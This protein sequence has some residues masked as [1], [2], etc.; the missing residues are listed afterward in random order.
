M[1][2]QSTSSPIFLTLISLI[3]LGLAISLGL[4][5]CGG[6]GDGGGGGPSMMVMPTPDAAPKV[7]SRP[8]N[9]SL[10]T[11]GRTSTRDLSTYFEDDEA[12]TY[13][14]STGDTEV[15]TV[16][17]SGTE[18]TVTSVG[19]GSAT[20][21]ITATDPGG[22]TAS[23][24]FT[25]TVTEPSGA[26]SGPPDLVI[27]SI[28]MR[29]AGPSSRR[30]EE[31]D[32]R[33]QVLNQGTG[34]ADRYRIRYLQS[35]DDLVIEPTDS[36]AASSDNRIGLNP[37]EGDE[38]TSADFDTPGAGTYYYGAC[39]E[40]TEAD[41]DE[42]NTD[43]NCSNATQVIVRADGSVSITELGSGGSPPPPPSGD[44][45]GNTQATATSIAGSA[46]GRIDPAGDV[47]YFSFRVSSSGT[48][49]VATSGSTDTVCTLYDSGGSQLANDDDGG[50]GTNCQI[51][52]SVSTGTYA[53][54]VGGFSTTTT[55]D[56]SLSVRTTGG[57]TPPPGGGSG[58]LTVQFTDTCR[59]PLTYRFFAYD[60]NDNQIG[61]W[62]EEGLVYPGRDFGRTYTHRLSCSG[63]VA[64]VCYG[65]RSDDRSS[66]W[67]VDIDGSRGCTGCCSTCTT[68]TVRHGITCP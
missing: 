25:T 59:L 31:L 40:V 50:S 58:T 14:A 12:L 6:G 54:R 64:R 60:N 7:V 9:L 57:T 68:G 42:T 66:S 11:G 38:H 28:S 46:T 36:R 19:A 61:V 10:N 52:R 51:E 23:T 3:L 62:P 13:T 2:K 22:L 49:T 44:D 17:V 34:R 48:L 65:A 55:G 39:V 33:V 37:T 41:T 29:T 47:D 32:I 67:G 16:S 15:A 18:L 45:H 5:S 21:S 8:G 4:T 53:V 63:G 26:P 30:E 43:N 1:Q 27:S 20:I 35:E 24:S 56:Y